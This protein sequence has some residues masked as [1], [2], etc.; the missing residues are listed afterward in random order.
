MNSVRP[1]EVNG[2]VLANAADN[3]LL[4]FRIGMVIFTLLLFCFVFW[5]LE[6]G[7]RLRDWKQEWTINLR[8]TLGSFL[9]LILV[10]IPI[11]SKRLLVSRMDSKPVSRLIFRV[12][13]LTLWDIV[14][15]IGFLVIQLLISA[16]IKTTES[17]SLLSLESFA[18][19]IGCIL[20]FILFP[21]LL[22]G[23][24]AVII[25]NFYSK[26]RRNVV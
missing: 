4:T 25:R 18:I 16:I 10:T 22:G 5:V 11:V 7:P 26:L 21:I 12:A 13:T 8:W 19:S 20:V 17:Y 9:L 23:S 14:L 6:S 2:G 3:R 1:N 24:V 15:S